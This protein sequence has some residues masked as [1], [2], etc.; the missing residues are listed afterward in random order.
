MTNPDETCDAEMCMLPAARSGTVE[1][2]GRNVELR[3]CEE[4]LKQ[5]EAGKVRE[6]RQSRKADGTWNR[7][8]ALFHR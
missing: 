7:V 2:P 3:L 6:L 8:V 4:H 5:V 1:L